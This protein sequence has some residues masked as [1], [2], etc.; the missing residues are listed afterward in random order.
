MDSHLNVEVGGVFDEMIGSL[1]SA[2]TGRLK[3]IGTDLAS[4]VEHHTANPALR[5]SKTKR[6][7]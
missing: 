4:V 1:V 6:R 2:H 7:S 5:L 3:V